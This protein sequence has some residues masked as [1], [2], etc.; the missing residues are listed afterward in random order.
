MGS[1]PKSVVTGPRAARGLIGG[2]ADGTAIHDDEASEISAIANKALPAANDMIILED[3]AA[4]NVKK[5]IKLDDL[6]KY[7]I[8]GP[9]PN[10][11]NT[12][13]A[14]QFASV[15]SDNCTLNSY[16]LTEDKDNG[17]VKRCDS[18]KDILALLP[19][20]V[21]FKDE[22]NMVSDSA[23]HVCSQQSIKKYVDDEVAGGGGGVAQSYIDE[24]LAIGESNKQWIACPIDLTSGE[25]LQIAQIEIHLQDAD[26]NDMVEHVRLITWDDDDN[27]TSQYDEG[28]DRNAAGKYT[29]D[30][31]PDADLSGETRAV[32]ILELALAS[33][34]NLDI[35]YVR[36]Q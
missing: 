7:L 20:S 31:D 22:D 17:V 29:Y 30:I 11:I 26:E 33:I 4:A 19:S 14:N 16:I 21:Q 18:I 32:V 5:M 25:S 13:T 9:V 15:G 36:V 28:T 24:R 6:R 10:F 12:G 27:A 34:M 3:S 8:T 1:H 23:V 2:G 35:T